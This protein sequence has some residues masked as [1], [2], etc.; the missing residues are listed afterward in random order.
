MLPAAYAGRMLINAS[1]G[2]IGS[3]VLITMSFVAWLGVGWPAGTTPVPRVTLSVKGD[4][5]PLTAVT[6]MR[7]GPPAPPTT[8]GNGAAGNDA[9]FT[10]IVSAVPPVEAATG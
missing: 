2:M 3:G 6:C 1:V 9:A 7:S 5:A 10:T 8:M 4:D